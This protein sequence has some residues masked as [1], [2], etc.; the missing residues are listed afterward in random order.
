MV[1]FGTVFVAAMLSPYTYKYIYYVLPASLLIAVLLIANMV[2]RRRVYMY[3]DL[4]RR[5][6][7]QENE[8]T[9]PLLRSRYVRQVNRYTDPEGSNVDGVPAI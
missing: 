3:P 2:V 9:Q 4:D 6:R 5:Y 8:E 7:Q 1:R